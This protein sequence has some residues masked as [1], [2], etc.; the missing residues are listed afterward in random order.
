M[1]VQ[2]KGEGF[3][4]PTEALPAT[5]G[6]VHPVVLSLPSGTPFVKADYVAIGYTHYEVMCIGAVGGQGGMVPSTSDWSHGG[7]GGGGGSHRV[8]GLL[9]GLPDSVAVT[10]GQPGTAGVSGNGQ[11]THNM[12]TYY[13]SS[14]GETEL[15]V[16]T[17]ARPLTHN[18]VVYI[19]GAGVVQAPY[20]MLPGIPYV[21]TV[22]AAY[23]APQDGGDGGYSS[24]GTVCKASGGKGGKKSPIY[25]IY[26]VQYGGVQD[27]PGGNGGQGG[28]GNRTAAGGGAAGGSTTTGSTLV[29]AAD[30]TWN[31]EVG[32]GGGG[33]RGGTKWGHIDPA[34]NGGHGSFSY[35]DTSVYGPRQLLS[36][37]PANG[38]PIVP[39][40]GGGAKIS[41]SQI[42]GSRFSEASPQGI[43]AIRLFKVV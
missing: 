39:G 10:V 16:D 35:G 31:G 30:G 20:V 4:N 12:V 40:S 9:S 29:E 28:I 41:S 14:N 3:P 11:T 32:S 17:G 25:V 6:D 15:V 7:A 2:L 37:D 38:A 24:F 36:N 23:I 43:V 21:L 8:A 18:G 22:N 26:N 27:V 19:N 34:G 5:S 42:F 1:R 13:N 33:G